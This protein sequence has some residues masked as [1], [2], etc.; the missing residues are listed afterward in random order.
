MEFRDL[1]GTSESRKIG[2]RWES[3]LQRASFPSG[4]RCVHALP[5][6]SKKDYTNPCTNQSADKHEVF[7]VGETIREKIYLAT[8]DRVFCKVIFAQDDTFVLAPIPSPDAMHLPDTFTFRR[9]VKA[10]RR[11]FVRIQ[12]AIGGLASGH[13]KRPRPV[14]N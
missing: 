7:R 2:P 9:A 3:A 4:R 12:H 11:T 10:P 1:R 5:T 13:R 6:A 8:T 14:R